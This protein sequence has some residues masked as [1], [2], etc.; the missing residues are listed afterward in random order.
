M[1]WITSP[2]DVSLAERLSRQA[3]ISPVCGALLTQRGIDSKRAA[4]AFLAPKLRDLDDPFRITNLESAVK[5]LRRAMAEGESILIFGDY[6]VDGV[7]STS[8]LVSVLQSFGVFPRYTV[9]RRLEE[10][11]GLSREAIDRALEGGIPDLLVAVDCGT[12][13]VEEAQYLSSQG[14]DLIV[15]DH[16]VSREA[17]PEEAI[18]VNPHVHDGE[19][20]PWSQL[21]AVGLVFKLAHGLVKALR[22]E[23]DETARGTRLK[24][25]LDLV[26]LGT[27]ADLVP[28]VAENRILA[29]AGLKRLQ[30]STRVGLNAL[31]EV[32]GMKLGQR[33]SPFDI[34]FR[35]G[36]RINA[37]GRLA[38][39]SEPIEM[40]L[41]SD[42]RRCLGSAG[43]LDGFNRERQEIER[44]ITEQAG[45]L[46]EEQFA[47]AAGLVLHDETWHPG[48]VGIVASRISQRFH[49]PTIVL[50]S[51]E[52]I[53]RGSGR[54]IPGVNLV[55]ALA[56]CAPLLNSWG[57]HPMAVGVGLD[58]GN[59]DRFRE[60]F[61][62]AVLAHVDGELP[63]PTLALASWLRPSDLSEFLLD[64]L[65]RLHPFGQG[66]P[67]PVFGLRRIRLHREPETFGNGHC[68][69]WLET[70][71]GRAIS[72]VAWRGAENAPPAREPVDMALRLMWNEWNGRRHPRVTLVDWRPAAD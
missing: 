46:A 27:I 13:S 9:P 69:F 30:H 15:V 6:D 48:V 33:V 53:A 57:G 66:N 35:L 41:G 70:G 7:T 14:I 49:K 52:G 72:G 24:E 43:M 58:P 39:A 51:E 10:G 21:C 1:R 22:R 36:P 17:I 19:S 65:E 12:N 3:G 40:L 29:T 23:G 16:H 50:G 2:V 31:F 62:E 54:S 44:G 68:R 59:V 37:S 8:L 64:E 5:R 26:A 20:E 4:E 60:A 28:L 25:Y 67:E 55:E 45:C 38:D 47:D 32:S 63:E 42:Y 18:L 71:H 56:A 34:S 11:Y 61:H